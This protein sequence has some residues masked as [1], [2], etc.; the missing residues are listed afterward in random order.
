MRRF[1]QVLLFI[2]L[3]IVAAF[4]LIFILENNV[5][6]AISFLSL[7]SPTLPIAVFIV[8]AFLLG[9]VLALVIG[10]FVLLKVKIKLTLTKKQLAACKKELANKNSATL[11][12]K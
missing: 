9:L 3:L 10:Y 6:V 4:I 1:Q 7:T 8:T 11:L 5:E 2:M 12:A